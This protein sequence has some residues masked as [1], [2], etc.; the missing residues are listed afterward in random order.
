VNFEW[1]E[2]Q[3]AFRARVRDFIARE[4]PED[5]EH[6][7]RGG[8][9]SKEVTE[10]SMSF[11][12]KAAKEG[13]LVPHW[14]VEWGG[15]G[16]TAYEHFILGEEMWAAGEP[17][18][19]QYMSVNWIGV[20]I[21][22][23]GTEEQKRKYVPP[24]AE[25]RTLWCQGF[26]EPGAG[27]DLASLRTRAER[28][29]DRYVVNGQKIWTSYAGL[30]ETCF[31]LTRT[32]QGKGGIS[33]FLVPMDTK[34]ITVREI[35]SLVGAG[36][37]HEVFFDNMEVPESYLFGKEGE[38]WS[39]ITYALSNERV[40]IPRYAL[41]RKA[42]ERAVDLL[43]ARGEFKRA[44]VR[45]RAAQALAFCEAAR[46]LTYR[47]LDD[48]ARGL[49]PSPE[50]SV[51]RTAVAAAERNATEF[52]VEFVP[53]AISGADDLLL[54]HHQRAIV[55]SIA[56]GAAEIQLNLIANQLLRLPR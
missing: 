19:G 1:T 21:L 28:K 26:S 17:R 12:G 14:P 27:S 44:D 23:Y 10:F 24:M 32:G 8:P 39:I 37:I 52:V 20:T 22:K 51:A 40:G 7:S 33:I 49:P 43:K 54:E 2:Q 16:A 35:P 34:G 9:A 30:A 13:L 36:D 31:L 42:V 45:R 18:G 47:V 5:F 41:A 38:A 46:M 6:L 53:E 4:L 29:G 25:G 56:A 15:A 48:R 55:A 11:C 50:A 3:N